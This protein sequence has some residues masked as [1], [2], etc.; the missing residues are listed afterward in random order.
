MQVDSLQTLAAALLL[1]VGGD[2]QALDVA[3]LRD[4][5]DHVLLGD[6]VLDVEVLGRRRDVGAA[7]VGELLAHLAHLVLDDLQHEVHVAEHLRVPGD[8]LAQLLELVFDLVTLETGEAAQPHLEDRVGLDLREAEARD[9]GGLRLGV[10]GAGTDDPDDLVDI[11]ERDDETLEDVSPLLGLAQLVLG[12]PRDDV[13]L[14]LDVV[15]QHLLEVE[16]ARH[17]VDERQHD[18]AEA[19]LQLGVLV[20]LVEHDLRDARVGL[21]LDDDAHALAVRLVAQVADLGEL[22]LAYE[23]GDLRDELGLVHLVRDLGDDDP[24]APGRGLL[25]VRLAANRERAAA[26]LVRSPDSVSCP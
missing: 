13:L 6:E 7:L 25:D 17:A 2:R 10:V 24:R 22:L 14:V 4:R 1:T 23:V 26:R 11:V 20:E 19:L 21:E 8:L 16:R 15:V 5:D 9:E 18:H 3:R 12:T